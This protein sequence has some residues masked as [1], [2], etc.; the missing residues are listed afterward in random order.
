MTNK[1]K[2]IF[3]PMA[4][5]GRAKALDQRLQRLA[6]DLG[7][8]W[9]E[10]H[11]RGHAI[12]LARQ[13]AEEGF[14]CVVAI[15]GDGTV[16]E[17]V[18]GLMQIPRVARPCLGVVPVGSGNDYSS[19]VGMNPD[20]EAAIRQVMTGTSQPI[21]L[22]RLAMP[23]GRSEYWVNALGIGFD[24]LV[25][26]RSRQIPI[27]QGFALYLSAVL[28]AIIRDYHP[29][30][31]KVVA[32]GKI[33]E[34]ELLMLVLCNGRREGG[35]F[36]MSKDGR[37]DDGWFDYVGVRRVSRLG[38]LL[39]LPHFLDG[40]HTTLKHVFNGQFRKLEIISDA[41]LFIHADGEIL[42]GIDSQTRQLSVELLQGEFVVVH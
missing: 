35:G 40:T 11:H 3:N 1:T 39:T 38:M 28:E 16:H 23:D 41:P 29:F 15:G 2:F 22:G 5:F 34:D 20:P 18:N 27:V 8:V 21:D 14:S 24:T 42:T 10:T 12:D 36:Y 33:W 9:T 4:N 32:D 17:V 7:G 26:I 30:H 19:A 37:P 25:T 6:V 13:A 31:I